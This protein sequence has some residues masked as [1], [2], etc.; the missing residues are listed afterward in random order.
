MHLLQCIELLAEAFG[1]PE[2]AVRNVQSRV[3]GGCPMAAALEP[4]I[5]ADPCCRY[6]TSIGLGDAGRGRSPG[7]PRR[8]WLN[9]CVEVGFT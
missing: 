9:G 4:P 6:A 7:P 8:R 1:P 2:Q 5:S 3:S